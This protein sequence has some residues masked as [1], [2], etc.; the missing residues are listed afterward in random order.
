MRSTGTAQYAS[1]RA[2]QPA[3][4]RASRTIPPQPHSFAIASIES[5]VRIHTAQEDDIYDMIVTG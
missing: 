1:L 2:L 4:R 3:R 5:L